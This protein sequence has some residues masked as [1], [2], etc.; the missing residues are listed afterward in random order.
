[1]V[2]TLIER[3]ARKCRERI[4]VL[5]RTKSGNVEE[6]GTDKLF[7]LQN[8][9]MLDGRV[10]SYP[11]QRRGYSVTNCYL[12]R[13]PD[14]AWLIDTGF[15]G[16]EP[17]LRA[18]IESLIPRTLPLSLLP[19]RLNEFMS[20]QNIDPF[21]LYFNVK[22]CFTGNPDAAFWFDFGAGSELRPEHA[23]PAQHHHHQPRGNDPDRQ[24]R[25]PG[26]RLSG[27]DPPDRDA[28]DLRRSDQDDVHLRH[29]HAHLAR[30]AGR[31]LDHR[32]R[33]RRSDRFRP[34]ALVPAQHPLLVAGR[35][36]HREIAQGHRQDP[37]RST[38]SRRSRPATAASCAA[39]R[40]SRSTSRSSTT[41]SSRWTSRSRRRVTSA[42]TRND[43]GR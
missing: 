27:A 9:M 21:T 34:R 38:T 13:Q 36:R 41:C 29:V 19:L 11:A 22:E 30:P 10:S 39:R 24:P 31:P 3:P 42:A 16:D 35:R 40:P 15:G 18:Q 43:N 5:D 28:L 20:I 2:E 17:A 1:M 25:P 8:P 6:L 33:R 37:E 7:A 12:L 32:G 26:G 23:R 4:D 14:A